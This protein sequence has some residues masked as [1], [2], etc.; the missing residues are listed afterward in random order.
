MDIKEVDFGVVVS[1]DIVSDG[2]AV[3]AFLSNALIFVHYHIGENV[4]VA[5]SLSGNIAIDG[6]T[7][8]N[9]GSSTGTS[10]EQAIPHGLAAIPTG[11]KAWIKIEYPIGSGRYITKD[12]PYDVT[13]VYPTVDN[14]VAYEWGI[15]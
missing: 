10:S 9:S 3:T 4:Y 2:T 7:P 8:K 11:C 6:K 14:G 12:I 13:S 5:T 15:A 1:A